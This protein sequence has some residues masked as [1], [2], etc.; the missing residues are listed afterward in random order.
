MHFVDTDILVDILRGYPPAVK[1][2]A[3]VADEGLLLSGF[4]VMELMQG[5][6]NQAELRQVLRFVE[7]H[8]IDWP[9]A[10]TCRRA[11]DVFAS[12]YLSHGVGILDTLIGQ[13]AVDEGYPLCTFNVKHYSMIPGI[14]MEQPYQRQSKENE[15]VEA[16]EPSTNTASADGKRPAA[17]P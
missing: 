15:Q 16:A 3:A 4:V 2:L 9:D 14:R 11:A 12:T 17:R 7:S 13:M 5:C 6:R 8:Q 1:W 10:E